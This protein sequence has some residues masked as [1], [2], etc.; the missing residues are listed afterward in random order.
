M[1]YGGECAGEFIIRNRRGRNTIHGAGDFIARRR[2]QK[3]P[4]DIVH[5]NPGHP[6]AARTKPASQ[7]EP[8]RRQHF[9][10][11]PAGFT[12]HN[13]DAR[14]NYANTERAGTER[15][16]FPGL[17]YFRQIIFPGL[18]SLIQNLVSPRSVV[19]DCGRCD[20]NTRT[21]FERFERR[22]QIV[23]AKN[24]A[25]ANAVFFF[26]RPSPL[27]HGLA[28]QVKY[29]VHAFKRLSRRRARFGLPTEGLDVAES[30]F[31]SPN[32][33]RRRDRRL[34]AWTRYFTWRASPWP[35][36]DGRKKKKTA[37]ATA[38]FLALTIW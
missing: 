33:A 10:E 12:Q 19:T 25:V 16:L 2:M 5:V 22:H 9:F 3:K 7:T 30:F 21:V 8:E 29:R 26:F 31:G 4:D 18:G 23:S 34:K 15:L 28:R 35:R 1:K 6:M 37:F 36:G 38:A 20:E 24:A 11:R 14:R 27:G 32:R 13:S 17:A